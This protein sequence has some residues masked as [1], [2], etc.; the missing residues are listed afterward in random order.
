[1]AEIKT[2]E[3]MSKPLSVSTVAGDVPRTRPSRDSR[4]GILWTLHPKRILRKIELSRLISSPNCTSRCS[5]ASAVEFTPESSRLDRTRTEKSE[6]HPRESK[7][8]LQERQCEL[9]IRNDCILF[10]K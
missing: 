9:M 8:M 2:I 10:I 5:T 7:E 6:P 3:D 1:M 4:L